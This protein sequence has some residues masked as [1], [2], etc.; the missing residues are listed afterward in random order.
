MLFTQDRIR[1]R[2][3]FC[4]AWRKHLDDA[5]LEPLE[6]HIVDL[7][8]DH[9][10]YHALVENPDASLDTDFSDTHAAGNPF[11]HLGLHLALREQVGTDR[12]KG[13][14]SVTRS[15][16]LKHQDGHTVEHL[17]IEVLGEFLW[18]AQRANREPDQ[19]GYLEKLKALV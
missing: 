15:L 8:K 4:D 10:E 14:A 13:I 1:T 5:P 11:L 6:K 9:P 2:N 16:L 12:P 17:M 3:L 18:D 19:A 7:L